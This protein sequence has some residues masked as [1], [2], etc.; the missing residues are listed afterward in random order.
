MAPQASS[1]L[2][3]FTIHTLHYSVLLFVCLSQ[4]TISLKWPKMFLCL[5]QKRDK[6]REEERKRQ[7]NHCKF[8]K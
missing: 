1:L 6:A 4:A 8:N 2:Y 3:V 7:L 5:Q